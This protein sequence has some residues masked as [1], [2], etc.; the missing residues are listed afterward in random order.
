MT[1]RILSTTACEPDFQALSHEDRTA[2][3]EDLFAWVEDGPP[4]SES[5]LVG[6][7]VIFSD[8]LPC[9]YTVNYF[10]DDNERYLAVLRLRRSPG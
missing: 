5:R 9:G 6:G 2:V 8:L 7:A 1:W 3:V 4:R 10:I